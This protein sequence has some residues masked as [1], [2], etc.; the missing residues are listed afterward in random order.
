MPNIPA[1]RAWLAHDIMILTIFHA[2]VQLKDRMNEVADKEALCEAKIFKSTHQTGKKSRKNIGHIFCLLFPSEYIGLAF[3]L[4]LW[5]GYAVCMWALGSWVGC[6]RSPKEEYWKLAE[7][8]FVP[9]ELIQQFG[10]WHEEN[11]TCG[12]SYACSMGSCWW[13]C[14]KQLRDRGF[15]FHLG[16]YFEKRPMG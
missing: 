8:S 11:T 13:A 2:S 4:P 1:T 3:L 12:K 7:K 15:V 16:V 5:N 14:Q 9:C 10:V 6:K